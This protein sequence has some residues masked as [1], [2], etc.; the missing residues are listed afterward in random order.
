MSRV[1]DLILLNSDGSQEY[2]AE[3]D[4]LVAAHEQAQRQQA[5]LLTEMRKRD[6]RELTQAHK[7]ELSRLKA[8]HE[9]SVHAAK[10]EA[11]W[12]G[13]E[14]AAASEQHQAELS[15]RSQSQQAR[16][17]VTLRASETQRQQRV[18]ATARRML[19]R[20]KHRCISTAYNNWAE[21]TQAYRRERVLF[22]RG[23]SRFHHALVM[24]AVQGWLAT[25]VAQRR[26]RALLARVGGRLRQRGV[27]IAFGSWAETTQAYRRERAL[28]TRVVNRLAHACVSAAVQGWRA[29]AGE[30]CRQRAM[31]ARVG[32]RL[33]QRGVSMAM[34]TWQQ[35][36]CLAKAAQQAWLQAQ[37][38]ASA[39]RQAAL[40]AQQAEQLR[41]QEQALMAR[42]LTRMTHA[43]VSAGF[44][45]WWQRTSENLRQ[46]ALLSRAAARLLYL[47]A[48]K[49]LGAWRAHVVRG[50]RARKTAKLAQLTALNERL[51]HAATDSANTLKAT[52]DEMRQAG[53]TK[54]Q[55]VALE[56]K[57]TAAKHEAALAKLRQAHEMET[58]H[59]LLLAQEADAAH[60]AAMAE[61]TQRH[62]AAVKWQRE[63]QA[64]Q[65]QEA[66]AE[67]LATR[68]ARHADDVDVVRTELKQAAEEL[69][70][71]EEARHQHAVGKMR[72]GLTSQLAALQQLQQRV[73][74]YEAR[75]LELQQ[76]SSARR[77]YRIERTSRRVVARMR[78]AWVAACLREWREVAA[79][80]RR[81][82]R[83]SELTELRSKH[84]DVTRA[85]QASEADLGLKIN[86]LVEQHA[87]QLGIA[88]RRAQTETTT[89]EQQLLAAEL[90]V[91]AAETET[92]TCARQHDARM[93]GIAQAHEEALLAQV[94][95]HGKKEAALKTAH[96]AY[97]VEMRHQWVEHVCAHVVGKLWQS[98]ASKAFS[99]WQSTTAKKL[100]QWVV[101]ERAVNRLRNRAMSRALLTWAGQASKDRVFCEAAQTQA[102]LEHAVALLTKQVADSTHAAAKH[103]ED[104]LAERKVHAAAL[105]TARV[106]AQRETAQ[107]A[108][109]HAAQVAAA[110]RAH[111][112]EL[113]RTQR[114][115][116]DTI[117]ISSAAARRQDCAIA[118]LQESEQGLASSLAHEREQRRLLRAEWAEKTLRR[119]VGRMRN[120]ALSATFVGW[121]AATA[122]E[123]R[124]QTVLAVAVGRFRSRELAV[125]FATWD[126]ISQ[127][128][129]RTQQLLRWVVGRLQQQGCNA[130]L[131]LWKRNVDATRSVRNCEALRRAVHQANITSAELANATVESQRRGMV[132]VAQQE[133]KENELRA[134]HRTQ[135]AARVQEVL[136][137]ERAKRAEALAAERT[138]A[139]ELPD[140]QAQAIE[141]L[142]QEVLLATAALETERVGARR[143][144]EAERANAQA[145]VERAVREATEASLVLAQA[146][147]QN[148]QDRDACQCQLEATTTA[149]EI[150]RAA[151]VQD[152][153]TTATKLRVSEQLTTASEE[154]ASAERLELIGELALAREANAKL[155]AET[156]EQVGLQAE[157]G[158]KLLVWEDRWKSFACERRAVERKERAMA[159]KQ[160]KFEKW[161]ATHKSE[162]QT[163]V[164]EQQQKERT[165][166]AQA[167]RA[168]EDVMT[169]RAALARAREDVALVRQA[170]AIERQ[171]LEAATAEL[172]AMR[173]MLQVSRED[174]LPHQ[175]VASLPGALSPPASPALVSPSSPGTDASGSFHPHHYSGGILSTAAAT[176]V[177]RQQELTACTNKTM[178]ALQLAIR[179]SEKL[180]RSRQDE[181][182]MGIEQEISIASLLQELQHEFSSTAT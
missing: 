133:G 83:T 134:Q 135:L 6:I 27:S 170:A 41:K 116:G 37:T 3:V 102:A 48:S 50:V 58:A 47:G 155:M 10:L 77:L 93:E 96:E 32:G 12:R 151:L 115:L 147:E 73:G 174:E 14:Q 117:E 101:L 92:A 156:A 71:E 82:Q 29:A 138:A 162:L 19:S 52:V 107:L 159:K 140:S 15:E 120:S 62:R 176:A 111:A 80:N 74:S 67:E 35:A 166:M 143:A 179:G 33:R 69:A 137:N 65:L 126:A 70:T 4:T 112:V 5:E 34:W 161:M 1:G 157:N 182:A 44:E 28:L 173:A 105:E 100:Q 132:L 164:V 168:R 2:N 160:E 175:G 99:R 8:H 9:I 30:R 163:F 49:A 165:A 75:E 141:A 26:Q 59:R 81:W 53:L 63:Q 104:L 87:A 66:H 51:Q 72:Q 90:R 89:Y 149:F 64:Q 21:T 45:S 110:E 84:A 7:D 76:D 113:S 40:A 78:R 121:R 131:A 127:G 43:C 181:L 20:M 95:S 60:D 144:L 167:A 142:Q 88:Q 86:R 130:A 24:A 61:Q 31:L 38:D 106:A 55:E 128:Q 85:L 18:E 94:R 118:A 172:A 25:V 54:Q 114:E 108:Q 97:T 17:Q 154:R 13:S 46:R 36:T 16:E 123:R 180:A 68:K 103:R 146:S 158:R 79:V 177:A 119:V 57:R 178:E 145:Q 152:A 122:Q 125:A 153:T 11:E 136:L 56:A 150:E 148:A 109:A 39:Q 22:S 42:V 91:S 171:K 98:C 124:A 23:I 139:Q 129:Q 169:E